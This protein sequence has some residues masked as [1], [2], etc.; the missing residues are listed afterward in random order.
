M[1]KKQKFILFPNSLS[2][3]PINDYKNEDGISLM[4]HLMKVSK[5]T[6]L[7][8]K[9]LKDILVRTCFISTQKIKVSSFAN[10]SYC[11]IV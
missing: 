9:K 5:Y 7:N 10:T 2:L 4:M 11:F 6:K 1:K 8:M 3:T